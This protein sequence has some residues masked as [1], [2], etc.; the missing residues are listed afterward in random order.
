MR[1]W[2]TI[3]IPSKYDDIP[4]WDQI[5]AMVPFENDF[6]LVRLVGPVFSLGI[7]YIELKVWSEAKGQYVFPVKRRVCANW[8]SETFEHENRGCAYCERYQKSSIRYFQN[9]IVRSIQDAKPANTGTPSEYERT[10]QMVD[11]WKFYPIGGMT[12]QLWTPIRVLSIPEGSAKTLKQLSPLNVT[13]GPD[14]SVAYPLEDSQYGCDVWVKYSD[15]PGVAK[16]NMWQFSKGNPS[17]LEPDEKRFHAWDIQAI[18]NRKMA[19]WDPERQLLDW[20]DF[21]HSIKPKTQGNQYGERDGD[22]R[23]VGHDGYEQLPAPRGERY[24]RDPR[25]VDPR[26]AGPEDYAQLPAPRGGERNSRDPR[27]VDPRRVGPEG[28]GRQ[29]GEAPQNRLPPPS[30]APA[31]QSYDDDIPY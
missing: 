21:A 15:A 31:H 29:T 9:A 10:I 11:G 16:S 5:F 14:G 17:P 26:R 13:R 23:R 27:D 30:A 18:L 4:A 20:E 24:S 2:S 8:N 19:P 6:V 12:S 1:T 3:K 28:Y 7:H 22:S 25:D